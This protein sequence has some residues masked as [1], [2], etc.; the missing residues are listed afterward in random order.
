MSTVL[1]YFI[2]VFSD[3]YFAIYHFSILIIIKFY[4]SMKILFYVNDGP[5]CSMLKM[6]LFLL[7]RFCVIF[8][9]LYSFDVLTQLKI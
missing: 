2:H 8:P 9:V 6:D 4:A 5:I 3:K 1:N 7:V